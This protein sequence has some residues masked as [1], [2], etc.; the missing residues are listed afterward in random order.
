M[1]KNDTIGSLVASVAT[2]EDGAIG[3]SGYYT[4]DDGV[5]W[6]VHIRKKRALSS[7]AKELAEKVIEYFNVVNGTRYQVKTIQKNIATIVS[8]EPKV[9]FKQFEAIIIHKHETWGQDE[10]M[11]EFNRPSTLFGSY[12]KF[13]RYLDDA[14]Q[15]FNKVNRM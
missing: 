6:E 14:R 3:V 7:R 13:L 9:E 11:M 10:K 8:A 1:D 12:P 15:Y 4:D 5:E 2:R